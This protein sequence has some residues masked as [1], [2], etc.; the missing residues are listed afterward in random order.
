MRHLCRLGRALAQRGVGVDGFAN[1]HG[2][3]THLDGQWFPGRL[4]IKFL[5][6]TACQQQQTQPHY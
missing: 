6:K 5:S 3:R 2:I 1:V 4:Q